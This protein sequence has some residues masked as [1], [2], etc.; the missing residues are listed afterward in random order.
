M[1]D[2]LCMLNELFACTG[3]SA[4]DRV[5]H[6]RRVLCFF[7]KEQDAVITKLSFADC[8]DRLARLHFGSD[9]EQNLFFAHWDVSAHE[10]FS[11]LWF[12]HS[13]IVQMKQLA[14]Y[15]K[16]FL[17]IT[18]LREAVCPAGSYWTKKRQERYDQ[19]RNYISELVCLWSTSDSNVQ[20]AML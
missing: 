8:A 1:I 18:G 2:R 20:L 19:I 3:A 7:G 14:G 12:R 17:L 15:R 13:L 16:V 10:G 4:P 11:P 9:G 5:E 6:I